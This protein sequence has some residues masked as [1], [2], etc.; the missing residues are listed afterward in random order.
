MKKNIQVAI[1]GPASAGKSTV[2]KILAKKNGFIYCDTGAMYRALTLAAMEN[3]TNMDSEKDLLTLLNQLVISFNQQADGQHVFLNEKDV[4]LLIR[5]ND[6][7]NSVS[8]VSA[9]KSIREEMV[10]RQQKIAESNSIVMDGRDI[11]TVVLPNASLKIFLVASVTERAERRFKENISKGID[12]DFEA[13]K[14]EIADRDHYDSTRKNSPLVQAEDAILVDT[15]GLN[16]EE[17]V[18]KIEKLMETAI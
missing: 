12:T 14:K 9:Y 15:S 11:G 8:K 1:D 13:L 2:A 18:L 6:V 3:K 17:V 16:I 5:D 7:T 10:L 4:T